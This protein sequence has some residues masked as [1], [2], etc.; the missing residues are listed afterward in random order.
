MMFVIITLN[1]KKTFS[2]IKSETGAF[3][4]ALIHLYLVKAIELRNW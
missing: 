1:G 2:F 3:G 4:F